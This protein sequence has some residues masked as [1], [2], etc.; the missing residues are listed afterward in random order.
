M[1][2]S[3]EIVITGLGVASSIG[4]GIETFWNSL[5]NG[6]CGVAPFE[7]FD[8]KDLLDA[9]LNNPF[10]GAIKELDKKRIRPRKSIKV[11][12]RDIQVGVAAAD[13]AWEDA[14]LNEK[15]IDP[16]RQGIVYGAMMP[17]ADPSEI[18][19]LYEGAMDEQRN[20]VPSLFGNKM[21]AMYPLWMLKY[22]PNMTACHIGVA[23]DLRGPSN[24]L[25]VGDMGGVS[26]VI[27]AIRAIERGAADLMYAGGCNAS[28]MPQNQTHF[29]MFPET[30][31]T[32]DITKAY[33]PYD[34]NRD[35]MVVGECGGTLILETRESAES[36]DVSIY[37]KILGYGEAAE[38]VWN[39]G[40][41]FAPQQEEVKINVEKFT[42]KCISNAIKLAMERSGL[43]P[44][45]LAF[46]MAH[47]LGS[48][49]HDQKEAEAIAA[50]LG[51][52]VPVTCV[53]SATGYAFSG[54]S[55]VS[56]VAAVKALKEN[57]IP[58]IVNCAEPDPALPVNLV[59]GSPKPIEA[60]KKAALVVA[61][62]YYGQAAALV[63]SK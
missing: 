61:Y 19:P 16:E 8:T 53:N 13:Y 20:F 34:V 39:S 23:N 11:M 38:A 4:S 28:T 12:A 17:L 48:K 27:E 9:G 21:D 1:E 55:A 24:T 14:Q 3:P 25:V 22:L 35:G 52:D 41:D 32:S 50:V 57:T 30:T 62:N 5:M 51:S 31:E 29:Q 47:G 36:R 44:E 54:S 6:A 56:V 15:P 43:K 60:G 59:T 7:D 10:V 46:V 33:R 40:T 63:V 37:G 26:A 58:A 42:G 18:V 49:F 45:D 2:K